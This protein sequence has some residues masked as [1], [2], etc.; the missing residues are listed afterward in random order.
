MSRKVFILLGSFLICWGLFSCDSKK[1]GLTG[2]EQRKRLEEYRKNRQ[3]EIS[4][5][6]FW[7]EY[8]R[9]VIENRMAERALPFT[10]TLKVVIRE[11]STTRFYDLHGRISAGRLTYKK[12]RY[13]LGNGQSFISIK[14]KGD[15]LVLGNKNSF[16]YLKE[17]RGFYTKPFGPKRT[18][19]DKEIGEL[20]ALFLKGK[21]SLYKKEDPNFDRQKNYLHGLEVL[22][23]KADGSFETITYYNKANIVT[24]EYALSVI[25]HNILSLHIKDKKRQ[26]YTILKAAKSEIVLKQGEVVYYLKNLSK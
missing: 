10:D 9:T 12:P 7:Q 23:N 4:L 8:K 21:W 2:L 14:R 1:K 11:D 18:D 17:V 13:Q 19:E 20:D 5:K 22:E 16:T 24:K 25:N 15:E 6:G 26:D 3:E